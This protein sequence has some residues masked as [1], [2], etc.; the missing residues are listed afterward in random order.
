MNLSPLRA[1]GNKTIVVVNY[2][3]QGDTKNGNF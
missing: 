1:T 3:V 2:K